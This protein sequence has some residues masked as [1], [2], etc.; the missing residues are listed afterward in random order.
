MTLLTR[1]AILAAKDISEI[2]I[3]VPEWGGKVCIRS[4]SVGESDLYADYIL[5]QKGDKNANALAYLLTL[6]LV[7]NNGDKIFTEKDIVA[8][9]K[10]SRSAVERVALKCLEA[11]G[12]TVD[13][14]EDLE[15]N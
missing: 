15:K 9:A 11:N 7:D 12:L 2:Q 5:K 14:G 10:K 8:L 13:A 6:A 3:E 4:L 1:D